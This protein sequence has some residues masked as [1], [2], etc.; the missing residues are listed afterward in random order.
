MKAANLLSISSLSSIAK[1]SW[2]QSAGRLL[3]LVTL[4]SNTVRAKPEL[5]T[6]LT[7]SPTY[8]GHQFRYFFPL[9]DLVAACN[10]VFDAKRHVISEY[11]FLNAPKRSTYSRDLR[12]DIDAI[13][14]L[15][16]HLRQ[17]AN[18][19]FDTAEAF[20]ARRL[21]VFSHRAYIPL[22]GMSCK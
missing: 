8:H 20:L 6:N 2:N 19:P 10:R 7:I 13:A 5:K 11:L 21:D 9:I 3:G 15:L 17:A 1:P 22:L 16:D 18:L 12:D 14:V 4:Y